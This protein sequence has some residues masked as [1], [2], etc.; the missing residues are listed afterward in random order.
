MTLLI[1]QTINFIAFAH[2]SCAHIHR[3]SSFCYGLPLL[4]AGNVLNLY[5]DL[6]R[7]D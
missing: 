3:T 5:S 7:R 4:K 1:A 2:R 6:Q